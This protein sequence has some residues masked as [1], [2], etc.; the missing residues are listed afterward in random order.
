MTDNEANIVVGCV[1]F[2]HRTVR[3]TADVAAHVGARHPEVELFLPHI[4]GVL[5]A[6]DFVYH[7]LRVNSYLLYKLGML[8]GRLA[9]TYMVVVVRYNE[10]GQGEVRTVYPTTQPARGDTLRYIRPRRSS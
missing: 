4:C 10:Q 1:D 5:E 7:R 3:L 2:A 8:T 6:R 9:N